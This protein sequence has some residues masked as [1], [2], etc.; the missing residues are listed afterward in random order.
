MAR[1][2]AKQRLESRIAR[3][4]GRGSA[5]LSPAYPILLARDYWRALRRVEDWLLDKIP[6]WLSPSLELAQPRVDDLR[7]NV[8]G[9]LTVLRGNLEERFSDAGIAHLIRPYGERVDDKHRRVFQ[10]ALRSLVGVEILESERIRGPLLNSW[11]EDNVVLIKTIRDEAIPGMAV[12]IEQAFAQGMRHEELLKK[13]QREGLPVDRGTLRQRAKV[14]ARDQIS[15][16]NGQL[17]EYRQGRAGISEYDWM[18]VADGKRVRKLHRALHGTRR[19][20]DE[21]HPTEGHPGHAVQCRCT[22]RAHIDLDAILGTDSVVPVTPLG[23]AA[24][25]E[26]R[27]RQMPTIHQPTTITLP[28]ASP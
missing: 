16:L 19:S 6:I 28:G 18:S 21:P 27:R 23:I 10:A 17:T 12:D 1:R 20:W 2:T 25:A 7:S 4:T 15:K 14:I 26:H 5:A 24:L 9:A 11:V 8:L 13:W 22:A 3:R